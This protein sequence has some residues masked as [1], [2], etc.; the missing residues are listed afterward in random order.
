M[1]NHPTPKLKARPPW[2]FDRGRV[3]R[4]ERHRDFL[5]DRQRLRGI[6]SP[7]ARATTSHQAPRT[8][9]GGLRLVRGEPLRHAGRGRGPCRADCIQTP[10]EPPAAGGSS[11]PSRAGGAGR[12]HRRPQPLARLGGGGQIG[13]PRPR[14]TPRLPYRGPASATHSIASTRPELYYSSEDVVIVPGLMA[15][16]L[17]DLTEGHGTV[18]I[19]PSPAVGP[20]ALLRLRLAPFDCHKSDRDGLPASEGTRGSTSKGSTPWR[21]T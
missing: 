13:R 1:G 5:M 11:P 12:G 8:T 18:W 3:R 14:G 19:N 2:R 15:C 17:T 20:E 7:M 6:T 21:W 4:A 10:D 16:E 9:V